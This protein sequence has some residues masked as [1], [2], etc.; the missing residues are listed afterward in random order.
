MLNGHLFSALVPHQGWSGKFFNVHRFPHL[1]TMTMASRPYRLCLKSLGLM[2]YSSSTSKPYLCRHRKMF[3][4]VPIKYLYVHLRRIFL[5]SLISSLI[6][7]WNYF[8][9]RARSC[10]S[11]SRISGQSGAV[12]LRRSPVLGWVKLRLLACSICRKG[13]IPDPG[14]AVPP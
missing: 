14:G 7:K 11:T 13:V 2:R 3:L 10:S 8:S 12:Q 5:A 6:W 1:A 9:G 4:E